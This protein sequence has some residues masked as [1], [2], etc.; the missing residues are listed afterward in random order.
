MNAH[1]LTKNR[2]KLLVI[3]DDEGI[4]DLIKSVT[5]DMNFSVNCVNDFES[6]G[7]TF[8]TFNPDIIFL[9]LRLPGYD[10]VEVLHFLS[11]IGCK[12]KIFL[13][14]GMDKSTLMAAGE[15]GKLRNLDIASA[16]KKP[17]LIEDIRNALE[18]EYIY[19]SSFTSQDF[20]ALLGTGEFLLSYQPIMSLQPLGDAAIC[21][22]EVLPEWTSCDKT[23]RPLSLVVPRIAAANLLTAFT[24]G[25][26]DKALEM[27]AGWQAGG[28]HFGLTIRFE[29]AMFLDQAL[30]NYLSN[31][32][33]KYAVSPG[34]L[35]V[36]ITENAA[37]SREPLALDL[38]TRLRIKGFNVAIETDGTD[39]SRLDRLLHLPTCELR[40]RPQTCRA[41]AKRDPETEFNISTLISLCDKQDIA[42][43]A[44]GIDSQT[45]FAFLSD[46][47]CKTGRGEFFSKPLSASEIEGFVLNAGG[48]AEQRTIA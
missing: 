32:V 11:D 23:R 29:D 30:P 2:P 1:M 25:L 47:G 27:Y 18:S 37:L 17:F 13:I 8:R 4:T 12:A 28:L 35:T 39:V 40:L 24:H 42:V 48:M 26:I 15:V 5:E 22:V 45:A 31:V 3:D 36:C 6:I 20:Q 43:C 9:D 7:S 16:L 10:G 44:A 19:V 14:S 41:L 21:G 46:C 34:Q 38:L 33:D